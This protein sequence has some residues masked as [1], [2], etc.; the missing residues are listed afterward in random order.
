M[1]AFFGITEEQESLREIAGRFA[2]DKIRPISAELDEKAKFPA[3][4]IR[5]G[6][7]LGLINLT[8]PTEYGGSGL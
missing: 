7:S 5:E 8:L 4:L 2:A 1:S 6:H 3:D